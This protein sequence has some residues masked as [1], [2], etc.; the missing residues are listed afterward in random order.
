MLLAYVR[1]K[2][3]LLITNEML[4]K[5][6]IQHYKERIEYLNFVQNKYG[7]DVGLYYSIVQEVEQLYGLLNSLEYRLD[8]FKSEEEG[9]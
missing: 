6:S 8:M 3:T 1:L 2:G 7:T 4:L 9:E 5:D